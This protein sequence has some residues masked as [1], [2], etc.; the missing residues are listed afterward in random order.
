MIGPQVVPFRSAQYGVS[1]YMSNGGVPP[2]ELSSF[3][4]PYRAD[5]ATAYE[6][7]SHS[8]EL[9]LKIIR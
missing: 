1:P 9:E 2:S 6:K 5:K 4:F 8:R 3:Q 7:A